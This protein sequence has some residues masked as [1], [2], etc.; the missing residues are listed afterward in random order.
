MGIDTI[1][2]FGLALIFF[3]GI[4]YLILKERNKNKAH[5]ED[6]PIWSQDN[7]EPTKKNRTK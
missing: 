7:I 4:I 3:C 5:V 6:K 1:V 2:V